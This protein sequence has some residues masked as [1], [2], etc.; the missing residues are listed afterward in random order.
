MDIL[1]NPA[2]QTEGPPQSITD[3]IQIVANNP[4]ML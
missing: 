1:V 2:N 4:S 3:Q